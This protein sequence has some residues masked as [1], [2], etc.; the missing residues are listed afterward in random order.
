MAMD[1]KKRDQHG[2]SLIE[3]L[4]GMA[5]VA[6][7]ALAISSLFNSNA[8]AQRYILQKYESQDLATAIRTS[9]LTKTNFCSCNFNPGGAVM[10]LATTG[11]INIPRL[12]N[13]RD[14]ASCADAA[15]IAV[16]GQ[17]LPG[18][19]A[20]LRV[21]DITIENVQSPLLDNYMFSLRVSFEDQRDRT[22]IRPMIVPGLRATGTGPLSAMLFQTC[23]DIA[24]DPRSLCESS[25]GLKWNASLIPPCRFDLEGS[26]ATV[27]CAALRGTI[28]PIAGYGNG[29]RLPSFNPATGLPGTG[30]CIVP[31]ASNVK[32]TLE[33]LARVRESLHHTLQ[34]KIDQALN[35]RDNN[36]RIA[37]IFAVAGVDAQDSRAV[38][39][40]LQN[41]HAE[42]DEIVREIHRHMT[43]GIN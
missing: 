7:T 31:M 6:T 21:R 34:E 38:Y 20:G 4:V 39:A 12:I 10:N 28:V 40:F 36:A 9:L 43:E 18:S 42:D 29:C 13:P 24:L 26:Q 32:K 41:P 22:P 8:Q 23:G 5:I 33:Y 14:T 15:D 37:S 30:F 17:P 25:L 3:A 11:A 27:F 2:F 1:N 19:T 16:A 35:A